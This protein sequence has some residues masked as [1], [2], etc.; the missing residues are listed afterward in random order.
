M[1]TSVFHLDIALTYL[2]ILVFTHIFTHQGRKE[3]SDAQCLARWCP[4]EMTRREASQFL[5]LLPPASI[6]KKYLLGLLIFLE[7]K[8]HPIF[9]SWGRNREK[10]TLSLASNVVEA[11]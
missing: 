4:C 1:L 6:G 7:K 2:V 8:N 5:G 10:V 11:K 3:V 9:C